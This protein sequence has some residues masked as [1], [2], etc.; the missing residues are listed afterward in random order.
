MKALITTRMD[1]HHCHHRKEGRAPPLSDNS[2]ALCAVPKTA[3]THPP[4]HDAKRS[5]IHD[6]GDNNKNNNNN[7]NNRNNNNN[8]NNINHNHNCS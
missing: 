4:S 2:E 5:T 6:D 8:N 7:S 3:P 1:H